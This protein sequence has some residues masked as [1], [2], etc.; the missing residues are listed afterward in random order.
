MFAHAKKLVTPEFIILYSF[1]KQEFARLG[2]ALSKKMIA[3][4]ND[5]N[6]LKRLIR[7]AFRTSK[8][9]AIDLIFLARAGV[10]K[11]DNKTITARLGQTWEKLNT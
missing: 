11:V 7:E 1:N 6:R 8:L 10:A 9:P 3:K 5:R 4:A 2:L